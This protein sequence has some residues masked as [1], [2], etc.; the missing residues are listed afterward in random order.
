MSYTLNSHNFI[1]QLCLNKNKCFKMID[2]IYVIIFQRFGWYVSEIFFR[3]CLAGFLGL[4]RNHQL[5]C[6]L[7]G[8][9]SLYLHGLQPTRL[10]CPWDISGEEYWNGLPFPRLGDLPDP[11]IKPVSSGVL[12]QQVDSLPLSH[13]GR[14]TR[15]HLCSKQSVETYIHKQECLYSR[16]LTF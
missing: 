12:D 11:G 14:P 7:I 3:I 2:F 10:F 4:T 13:L 16:L 1:C 5:A 6:V 9:D 15:N 8:S